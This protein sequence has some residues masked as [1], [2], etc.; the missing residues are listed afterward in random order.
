MKKQAKRKLEEGLEKI[1]QVEAALNAA[2]SNLSGGD[3]DRVAVAL[4][5]CQQAREELELIIEKTK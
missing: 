4:F 5:R 2:I 1:R 3:F